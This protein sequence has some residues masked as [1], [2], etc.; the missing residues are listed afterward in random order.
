VPGVARRPHAIGRAGQGHP[1]CPPEEVIAALRANFHGALDL[2]YALSNEMI[3]VAFL[4][5]LSALTREQ[6]VSAIGQLA[7]ARE[8][9]GSTYSSGA[10]SFRGF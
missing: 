8:T 4:H 7:S 3:V 10:L 5:P 2:R 6:I 9:F 1:G